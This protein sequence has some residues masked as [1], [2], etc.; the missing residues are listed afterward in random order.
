M[1]RFVQGDNRTQ[2][3][4]CCSYSVADSGDRQLSYGARPNEVAK[5]VIDLAANTNA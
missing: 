1:K 5:P 4:F 2:S 3:R